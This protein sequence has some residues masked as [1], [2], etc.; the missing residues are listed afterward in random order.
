MSDADTLNALE[1]QQRAAYWKGEET[2]ARRMPAF[3]PQDPLQGM[4]LAEA[5]AIEEEVWNMEVE[6]QNAAEVTGLNRGPHGKQGRAA[7]DWV[8]EKGGELSPQALDDWVDQVVRT[9]GDVAL[10]DRPSYEKKA[11]FY[12]WVRKMES[13]DS[14]IPEPTSWR[15]RPTRDDKATDEFE[16]TQKPEQP[17]TPE[18]KAMKLDQQISADSLPD[19]IGVG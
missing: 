11:M 14:G 8:N 1:R 4:A 5:E 7:L 12:S 6:A 15:E 16:Q 3:L 19:S 10:Y 9:S 13:W 2:A 17:G 18:D